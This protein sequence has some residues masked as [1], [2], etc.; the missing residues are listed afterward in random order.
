MEHKSLYMT[1]KEVT[2]L[3][4]VSRR[5]LDRWHALRKGP[6]RS[7]VGRTILFSNKAISSWLASNETEPTRSFLE[8]SQ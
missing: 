3:L 4:S 8:E 7:K 2:H 5:T 6:A 1:P